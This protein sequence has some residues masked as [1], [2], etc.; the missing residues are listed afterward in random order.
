CEE[1]AEV[2]DP[3]KRLE[4]NLGPVL[5]SLVELVADKC[6]DTRFDPARTERDQPK[7]DVKAGAVRDKHRQ[8][9]LTYAVNQAEPQN[10]V[11]F[12]KKPVGE[13]AAQQREKVN[14]DD[15][16]VKNVFRAARAFGFRQINKHRRDEENGQNVPHPVKTE[17]LTSLVSDDVAN[18]FRDR[19]LRIR[20]N[21]VNGS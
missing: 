9:R 7:S 11:V 6:G 1:R 21:A 3:V 18:L 5:V 15:E 19:R 10:G 4:H 13:P 16:R 17:A 20:G 14:A 12:A 8:A 2:D